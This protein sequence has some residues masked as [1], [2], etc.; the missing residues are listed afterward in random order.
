MTFLL[1]YICMCILWAIFCLRIQ[2][3]LYGKLISKDF[4]VIVL[5]V[6]F[7]PIS[8]LIGIY[9]IPKDFSRNEFINES[10]NFK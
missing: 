10:K 3:I 9:R 2:H 4:I 7:A 5:N 8:L 1:L 6:V